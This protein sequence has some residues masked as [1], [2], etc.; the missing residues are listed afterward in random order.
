MAKLWVEKILAAYEAWDPNPVVTQA[1]AGHSPEITHEELKR[2]KAELGV[3]DL[4]CSF[5][6]GAY[7]DRTLIHGPSGNICGH[8]LGICLNQ[9]Y[10]PK[11]GRRMDFPRVHFDLHRFEDPGQIE[12]ILERLLFIENNDHRKLYEIDGYTEGVYDAIMSD[13]KWLERITP[14]PHEDNTPD[15]DPAPDLPDIVA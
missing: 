8:C 4:V 10:S 3:E 6:E 7:A 1:R 12:I 9:I 13:M 15:P 14:P 11:S 5:C 2:M